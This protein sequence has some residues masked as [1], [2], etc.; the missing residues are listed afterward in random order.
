MTICLQ[1]RTA[2]SEDFP[3]AVLVIDRMQRSPFL[4]VGSVGCPRLFLAAG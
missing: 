3:M 1:I 2:E 4:P